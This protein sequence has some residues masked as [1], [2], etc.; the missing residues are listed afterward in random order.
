V[1]EAEA[2]VLETLRGGRHFIGDIIESAHGV[3]R[4]LRERLLR[5]DLVTRSTNTGPR[6]LAATWI[7]L[8]VAKICVGLSR[9][10]PVGF[11]TMLVIASLFALPLVRLPRRTYRGDRVLKLRTAAAGGLRYTA[12]SA[13]ELLTAD[14]LALAFALFGAGGV[15][16]A[17]IGLLPSHARMV[18]A[19][20]AASS[21]SSCSSGGCGGGGCGGGC[22]G[23]S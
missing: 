19:Q 9:H 13:P 1:S 15:A 20:A 18:A 14:E 10:R 11:L 3:G 6:L 17:I 16:G 22:G 23:C 8:G 21:D 12:M 5:E 4:V 7:A 2:H